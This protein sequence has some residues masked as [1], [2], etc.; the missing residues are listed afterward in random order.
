LRHWL[1]DIDLPKF[2]NMDFNDPSIWKD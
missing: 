2:E 1:L